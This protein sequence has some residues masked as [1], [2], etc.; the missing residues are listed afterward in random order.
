[1]FDFIV[2]LIKDFGVWGL[3][4]SLALEASSIPFPGGL[5][6][7][8]FG[9]FLNLS[10]VEVFSYS[11]LAS[12]VYTVFSFIPYGIGYKLEDKL[13]EKTNAYKIERAQRWFKKCGVWSIAFTRPIGLGNYISYVAGVS[14]V[15]R[16][17]FAILTLIG[18]LPWTVTMLWLGSTG[19]LKSVTGFLDEFQ[20]YV[21]IA[22][23]LVIIIF[24]GYRYYKRKSCSTKDIVKE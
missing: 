9:Y 17:K 7:L 4:A 16:W 19:N 15:N 21:F 18:I 2:Q 13:K 20:M 8:T 24:F 6:T 3:L 22:L 11:I 5:V 12:G 23:G 10:L 1:M 14:K